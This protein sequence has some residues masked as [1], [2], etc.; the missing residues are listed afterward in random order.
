VSWDGNDDSGHKVGGGLYWARIRA[1]SDHLSQKV[2][3]L[4]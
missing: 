3:L 2:V 1:G 4:K